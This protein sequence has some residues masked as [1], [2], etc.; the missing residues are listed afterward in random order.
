MAFLEVKELS[1]VY[2]S[3]FG[4]SV[5]ALK[6]V[7]FTAEKGEFIAIMG[8]SGSGK[9]SLLNILA[10]L[11]QPTGGTLVLSGRDTR[12]IAPR[13]LASFRREHL[14]YVFQDMKLLDTFSL[15]DNIA[16]PLVLA[17]RPVEEI[18]KRTTA[19]SHSLSIE[20]LLD[21]YPFELSGGEKQRGAI[22]RALMNQPDLLL[23]D[24]PTGQ[25]DTHTSDETMA[26]FQHYYAKGQ[27]ILLVTHSVKAAAYASRVLF[28]R[29][30][31]IYAELYKENRGYAEQLEAISQLLTGATLRAFRAEE[32]ETS[33]GF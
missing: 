14:G 4:H 7:S 30:G 9:T 29:D 17:K 5:E 26:I 2:K 22:A 12:S 18:Q 13:D 20:A 16:L 11:S 28:L 31:R 21:K 6:G 3:R 10:G 33:H 19:L 24:E 8:E 1:K 23:A 25:L 27:T 15:R 32:Q